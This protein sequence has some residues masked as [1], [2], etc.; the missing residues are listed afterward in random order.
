VYQEIGVAPVRAQAVMK[1][2]NLLRAIEQAEK[3]FGW[4]K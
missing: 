4:N 3:P 1:R 2:E